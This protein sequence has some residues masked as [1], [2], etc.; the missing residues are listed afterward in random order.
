MRRT[1]SK[2]L[3]ALLTLSILLSFGPALAAGEAADSVYRNGNIY[4]VDEAF[5]KATAL[6][7]KGDRLVYVGGEAGVEAFIGPNTKV[8]DLGGKTVIPGLIE[9][10]MHINGLGESLLIIDAFWKPKDAIL[11]AV[12]AEAEKAQPGEWIQ[13]RGW[14]NTVWADDAFPSKE[15]LD[16]VAPNNPVSLQRADAHMFWF[17]SMALDLAGVTKDTP[18]PQGGEILKTADG[19]VLGCMTDNAALIVRNIIPGWTDEQLKQ[20]SLLAQEQLFS[21]GFTSAMD[22][23]VTAHQLDLYKELYEDGELKLRLYPLVMLTSTEGPEAD[24]VRGNK[25]TGMLYDDHL[26]IAACKIIGDGSLGARSSAMLEDYSD[27]A[28]YK[29]EYRFTDEEA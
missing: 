15:D 27:R 6:A 28:G 19:E 23:G 25:P 14:M 4:T 2:V 22:A 17:N 8:T 3:A 18:N 7:I 20:A 1:L 12:K 24:Y 16:A 10:H 9:G 11:A 26:H 13:G 21:Y 29:G 5:S